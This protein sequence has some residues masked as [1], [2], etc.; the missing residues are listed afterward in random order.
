[1][2]KSI[3]VRYFTTI[4]CILLVCLV[5]MSSILLVFTKQQWKNEKDSLLS[6]NVHTISE[7]SSETL[8]SGLN[9]REELGSTVAVIGKIIGA[10]IFIVDSNGR[11]ILCTDNDAHCRHRQNTLDS[12]IMQKALASDATFSGRLSGVYETACYTVTTPIMYHGNAVGAVFASTP[13]SGANVAVV[14]MLKILLVCSLFVLL[15]AFAV[16]YIISSQMTRPLRQMALAAKQMENGVF[17]QIPAVKRRDEIGLL[18]EAF[19]RMSHS[20]SQL[21]DMRRSF[22]SSV[23]H[24]LKTPMT[25]ISGFVDGMLDGTIKNEDYPKYLHI[26]SDETKRLS[27]LVNSML[28]LSRLENDSVKLNY[29]SFN[30]SELLLRIMLS[31]ESKIEAKQIDI[32]GLE[33]TG[34]VM[35]YADSDLMY[36]VLYNLVENAIKFTP[37]QGYIYIRVEEDRGFVRIA[38]ENSGEGLNSV[39]LS[40]VFERFY[41]TDRSR[42]QDKTGMGFGLYIVKMIVGLHKGQINAES[43]VNEYTRFTV[44]LPNDAQTPIKIAEE[45]QPADKRFKNYSPKKQ[46]NDDNVYDVSISDISDITNDGKGDSSD[47]RL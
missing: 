25:T 8:S 33:D 3:F 17:V 43:V 46:P 28:Q 14:Q 32:R 23:S 37:E 44:V 4:A 36:Q 21:E 2:Q 22:I 15:V 24:E 10:D 18:V 41:K 29:S 13:L 40:R 27:R 9:F 5:F 6:T 1:M 26:V 16:V 31:F 30:V 42:S 20:L 45:T 12:K 47:G 19:N 7:F 35:L 11:V 38:I 39:E 34:K